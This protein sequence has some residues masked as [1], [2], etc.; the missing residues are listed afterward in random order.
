MG[1]L[2]R[3]DVEYQLGDTRMRGL[4]V[5]PS[6][7]HAL[8][9]VLLIH[10]AF[11]LGDEMIQHAMDLAERGYAV[12]ALDVWGDRF[13]PK[14]Q[15]EIGA[16]MGAMVGNRSE[17]HARLLAGY[18]AALRQ[19]EVDR[20]HLAVLGY[21]FGGSSALEFLRIGGLARGAIAIHPGLDI[22]END[23]SAAVPGAQVF[24]AAGALDPM[25]TAEQRAFLEAGLD[26]AQIDWETALYSGTVHAFT[27]VN[28]Q[29]SPHPEVFSY[30]PHNAVRAW[31]ATVRALGEMLPPVSGDEPRT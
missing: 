2:S 3:R 15:P 17:W 25:A 9:A 24:V 8:P 4:L 12:F 30:H 6:A 29:N 14:A 19:P 18:E 22:T 5:H 27:S 28:A 31:T 11:G 23:W 16:L 26:G 7:A 13:T 21:C 20:D 1:D 10:D